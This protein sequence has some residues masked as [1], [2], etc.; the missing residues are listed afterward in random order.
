MDHH[1]MNNF[2][3]DNKLTIIDQAS[4]EVRDLIK[5]WCRHEYSYYGVDYS[6]YPHRKQTMTDI[7]SYYHKDS[8]PT[9][10]SVLSCRYYECFFCHFKFTNVHYMAVLSKY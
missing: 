9:G 8:F 10:W 7:I 2:I 4:D 1:F 5:E 6:S 3:V